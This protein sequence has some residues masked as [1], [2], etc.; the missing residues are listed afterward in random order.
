M[1]SILN[2]V[3]R[4]EKAYELLERLVAAYDGYIAAM[5]ADEP[6]FPA[7]VSLHRTVHVARSFLAKYNR[8]ATGRKHA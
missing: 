2:D 3:N 5:K 8:G 7:S 6:L 1:K 4:L